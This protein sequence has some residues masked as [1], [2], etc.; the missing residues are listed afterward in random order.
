MSRFIERGWQ[1][2]PMV[3]RSA[4][5][6]GVTLLAGTDSVPHGNIAA[7]IALLAASGVPATIA[8]GAASWTARSFLDVPSL[9]EG[10]PADIVVYDEDPTLDTRAV[11]H[12]ALIITKGRIRPV[13]R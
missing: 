2:H 8:L 3:V 7:E 12:P 6:A 10:S 9:E 1:Q 11:A 4:F 13:R 5:E